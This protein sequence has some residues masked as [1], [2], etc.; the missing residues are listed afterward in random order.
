[1]RLAGIHAVGYRTDGR[2]LLLHRSIFKPANKHEVEYFWDLGKFASTCWAANPSLWAKSPPKQLVFPVTS[3]ARLAAA[4]ALAQHHI[5]QPFIVVCPGGVVDAQHQARIWPRFYDF[6]RALVGKGYKVVTCPAPSEVFE[7]RR[8]LPE[9]T[10]IAGLSLNELAAV[11]QN[12]D[13]V[14]SSDTGPMH[15]A[16]AV[17]TPCLGIFGPTTPGRTRPWNGHYVGGLSG[18]WPSWEDVGTAFEALTNDGA[19]K[20]RNCSVGSAKTSFQL[21]IDESKE[22]PADGSRTKSA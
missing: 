21:A 5:D 1:M 12:A 3:E 17:A 22:L 8:L 14:V 19:V 18:Q 13:K 6:C 7:Y 11:L 15:L 2:R 9:V 20:S 4:R 16:T 10:T